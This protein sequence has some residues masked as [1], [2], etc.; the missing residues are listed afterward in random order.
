V[1]FREDCAR[2]IQ[3]PTACPKDLLNNV[4]YHEYHLVETTIHLG[5]SLISRSKKCKVGSLRV[6]MGNPK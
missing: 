2:I 6:D 4:I 1:D 5:V 3:V